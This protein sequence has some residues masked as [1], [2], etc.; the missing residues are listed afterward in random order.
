MSNAILKYINRLNNKIN[1]LTKRIKSLEKQNK[2]LKK[3]S[4]NSYKSLLKN[5][6]ANPN[7]TNEI[8]HEKILFKIKDD[9]DNGNVLTVTK[10]GNEEETFYHLYIGNTLIDV[11]TELYTTD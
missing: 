9:T 3:K 10:H 11:S 7:E 5:V 6:E 2:Q 8:T 4:N 1:N